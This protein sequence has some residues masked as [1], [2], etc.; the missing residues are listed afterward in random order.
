MKKK[1]KSLL[2][3]D[4]FS[5][6]SLHLTSGQRLPVGDAN[7]MAISPRKNEVVVFTPDGNFH[8]VEVSQIVDLEVA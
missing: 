6:F 1:L 4:P 2:N 7:S 8:L 5:A 3:R